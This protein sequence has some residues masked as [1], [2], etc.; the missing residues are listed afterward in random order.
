[1]DHLEVGS[2]PAV[3]IMQGYAM[4]PRTYL[5]LAKLLSSRCRVIV[6]SL[7]GGDGRWSSAQ[8]VRDL[9][10]TLDALQLERVTMIGHSFGGGLQLNFA[11]LHPDRV[12]EAVFVDTLAMSREWTLAAEALHPVHLLWMA[13]PR[14]AVD[15]AHSWVTHPLRLAQ[16]A[17]WGFTSDRREEVA[18]LSA[19]EFPKHVLWANRDSLLTRAD[20]QRFA[21]DM[22]ADFKVVDGPGGAPVDHDWLY[23]HPDIAVRELQQ[24]GL[25]VLEGS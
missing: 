18:R 14:A 25:R 3:V 15:F 13:S 17:W 12:N 1:M 16:A 11:A 4:Q 23:R 10:A 22:G 21:R 7:F 2:G 8:V 24:V 6:P 9:S 5:R 20:G 19:S